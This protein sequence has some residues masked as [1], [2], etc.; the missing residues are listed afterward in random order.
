LYEQTYTFDDD[1]P[2][3]DEQ[4]LNEQRLAA[5]DARLGRAM[6]AVDTTDGLAKHR[7][8]QRAKAKT[9]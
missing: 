4:R 1:D 8:E 5:L 9:A 3:L 6:L 7:A 2:F